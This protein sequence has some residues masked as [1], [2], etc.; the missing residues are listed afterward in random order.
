M[1]AT[2]LMLHLRPFSFDDLPSD[3]K[4]KRIEPESW[5]PKYSK[6]AKPGKVRHVEPPTNAP[7]GQPYEFSDERHRAKLR[8]EFETKANADRR[9]WAMGKLSLDRV[10]LHGGIREAYKAAMAAKRDRLA[11]EALPV[12]Y[13]IARAA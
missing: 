6:P 11:R 1:N 8:A 5:G 13:P 10:G 12:R 9:D 2:E 7:S 3:L 4:G